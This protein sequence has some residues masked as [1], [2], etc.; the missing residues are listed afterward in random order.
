MPTARSKQSLAPDF[1]IVDALVDES[2]REAK[3]C[4]TEAFEVGAPRIFL[5]RIPTPLV[6]SH[7]LVDLNPKRV[8]ANVQ[9]RAPLRN[10]ETSIPDSFLAA[11]PF[12]DLNPVG[13][14][15]SRTRKALAPGWAFFARSNGCGHIF[16][17]TFRLKDSFNL[18]G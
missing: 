1:H 16:G 11:S 8:V 7:T 13:S 3:G 17:R 14:L 6:L 15:S 12:F 10:A 2:L 5:V 9:L 18:L 4:A